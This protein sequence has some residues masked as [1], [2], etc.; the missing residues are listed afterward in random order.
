V[1]AFSVFVVLAVLTI[2]TV[3]NVLDK[4]CVFPLLLPKWFNPSKDNLFS[5]IG[6]RVVNGNGGDGDADTET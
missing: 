6:G 5:I 4:D 1:L 2:L 3:E